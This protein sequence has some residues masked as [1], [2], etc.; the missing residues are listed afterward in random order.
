VAGYGRLFRE[1]ATLALTAS[2]GWNLAPQCQGGKSGFL[3]WTTQFHV[4]R[5][6]LHAA[7]RCPYSFR[8]DPLVQVRVWR[9]RQSWAAHQLRDAHADRE[10]EKPD[11]HDIPC[12]PFHRQP[13]SCL[14]L[15]A[16]QRPNA[17]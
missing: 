4:N 8:A 13:R 17:M 6:M 2:G 12:C 1:G 16:L 3:D 14:Q 9:A 10:A 11:D 15:A 5:A 7:L